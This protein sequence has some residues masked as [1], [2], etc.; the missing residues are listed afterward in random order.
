MSKKVMNI[1][2]FQILRALER[3]EAGIDLASKTPVPLYCSRRDLGH[4]EPYLLSRDC[5]DWRVHVFSLP[6]LPQFL[7]PTEGCAPSIQK[8]ASVLSCLKGKVMAN[9]SIGFAVH[10]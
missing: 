8:N 10:S 3:T 5:L 2:T 1:N 4:N 7:E 9:Q 6:C